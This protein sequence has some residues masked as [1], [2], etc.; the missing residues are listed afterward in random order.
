MEAEYRV[1]YNYTAQVGHSIRGN[2]SNIY[3]FHYT[4]VSMWDHIKGTCLV[5]PHSKKRGGRGESPLLVMT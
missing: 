4:A 5:K 1:L 2:Q 3:S